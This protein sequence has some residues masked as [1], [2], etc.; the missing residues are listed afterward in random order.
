VGELSITDRS[1]KSKNG[2]SRAKEDVVNSWEDELSSG[3]DT[4]TDI[5]SF[6]AKTNGLPAAPPPTPVSLTSVSWREEFAGPYFVEK[7]E[8]TRNVN[9]GSGPRKSESRPE[10]TDTVARRM[11]AGALGVR[12]PKMTEEGK[13]YEKA[14]RERERKKQDQEREA[15]KRAEEDMQR[16]KAAVWGD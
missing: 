11:I 13:E 15:R 3:E 6:P 9:G 14:V 1:R 5:T 10:K 8:G 16:A 4:E 7:I 2:S 12:A